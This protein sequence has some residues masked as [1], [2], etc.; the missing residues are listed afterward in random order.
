LRKIR[1]FILILVL[2]PS[3]LGTLLLTECKNR[4]KVEEV[5]RAPILTEPREVYDSLLEA[6]L[7]GKTLLYTDNLTGR[8]VWNEAP[9]MESLLNMYEVT[10]D[11]RYLEI[12]VEHA[13]HVLQMRDDYARRPD[14][15]G[16][17]RPGWQAGAYYTLGVPVI[18]PDERGYPSLE[19]QG[20]HQVGNN[21]TVV[22]ITQEDHGRFTLHIRN[23][24]RRSKPLEV[25]FEGL[26]L[27]NVEAW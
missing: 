27:K 13:D 23:D 6:I 26:T 3:I 17:L 14:Y 22:E 20:I 8:I 9:F 25:K 24:F 11:R 7:F 10:K 12:F 4:G 16:R 19:I 18:I 15:A 5:S 2:L 21:H 1:L